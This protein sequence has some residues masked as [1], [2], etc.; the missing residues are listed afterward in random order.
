MANK[1]QYYYNSAW[2]DISDYVQNVSLVPF[3]IRNRNYTAGIATF[4]FDVAVTVRDHTSINSSTFEFSG[5]EKIKVLDTNDKILF[6]GYIEK[7]I[8][9]YEENI[10]SLSVPS[11]LLKLRTF[12][13]D[14]DTIH[15]AINAIGAAWN[16]YTP[17]GSCYYKFPTVG[18]TW[19]LKKIFYVA[20]GTTLDTSEID[21]TA[22]LA[23]GQTL[24]VT[25]IRP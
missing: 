10:F 19:L 4:T 6:G 3:T 2:V 7:S 17:Y 20:F 8:F 13:L 24:I 12:L 23:T 21:A 25:G 1:I 22:T 5:D 14:Y 15:S 9:N 18:F 16:E 11:S